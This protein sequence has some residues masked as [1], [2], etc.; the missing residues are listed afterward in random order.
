ML[1]LIHMTRMR[2]DEDEGGADDAKNDDNNKEDEPS[3]DNDH[4][5]NGE[6]NADGANKDISVTDKR[7]S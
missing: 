3:Q 7:H 5:P 2:H 4:A 6:H 1:T